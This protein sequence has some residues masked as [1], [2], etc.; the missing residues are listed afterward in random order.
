MFD[1]LHVFD[2]GIIRNFTDWTFLVIQQHNQL[3]LTLLVSI[4]NERYAVIPP[5][6]RLPYLLPFRLK[7]DDLHAG[8]SGKIRRL[9]APFLWLCVLGVSDKDPDEDN[10]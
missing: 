6:A 8:M 4:L 7:S 2:L 1:K 3:P 9:S 5:S 10:V